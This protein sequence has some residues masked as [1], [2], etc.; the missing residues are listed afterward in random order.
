MKII[1]PYYALEVTLWAIEVTYSS[2]A[3]MVHAL[4]PTFGR[5]RQADLC[6]FKASL[7]YRVI[8]LSNL[9]ALRGSLPLL[10]QRWD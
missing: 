3:S 7:V 4:I 1:F 2:R 10:P 8:L 9:Q 6:E 5:H